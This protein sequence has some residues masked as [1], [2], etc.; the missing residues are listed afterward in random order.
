MSKV[1]VVQESLG[2]NLLP[3]R[4]FG[5]VKI[6]LPPGQ[7]MFSVAPTIKRLT[8][9]LRSFSND[10]Y[11][12]CMGDPAAIGLACA[13]AARFNAGRFKLLKWDKQEK[14]YFEIDCNLDRR[15]DE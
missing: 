9:E 3:A 15:N 11:I 7:I 2:R 6:L 13:V 5:E 4:H 14:S 1:Y 12:L 8:M 10:D